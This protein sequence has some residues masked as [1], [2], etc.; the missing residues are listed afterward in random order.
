MAPRS[1][2]LSPQES[3]AL[4]RL[5]LE[6]CNIPIPY[7]HP[8]AD[9]CGSSASSGELWRPPDSPYSPSDS[10]YFFGELP[11]LFSHVCVCLCIAVSD[12]SHAHI[13]GG[14]VKTKP[15][16][17]FQ[18]EILQAGNQILLMFCCIGAMI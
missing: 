12:I 16:L 11:H 7:N 2:E 15:K 14:A 1:D 6:L 4:V 5:N 8:D 18:T 3:Q 13:L 10:E 17:A 9:S